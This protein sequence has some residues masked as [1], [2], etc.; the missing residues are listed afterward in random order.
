MDKYSSKERE[1]LKYVENNYGKRKNQLLCKKSK[2][3]AHFA[4]LLDIQQIYYIREKCCYDKNS[5]WCY[6]D[7]YFPK[8]RLAIEID[9][10]EHLTPKHKYRDEMKTKFL[11]EKRKIITIRF[12]NE[13]VI[14]MNDF[15]IYGAIISAFK[16]LSDKEQQIIKLKIKSRDISKKGI[17][18]L[19]KKISFDLEI[20]IY[21]YGKNTDVIYTFR[22]YQD[23][24]NSTDMKNKDL[25][26]ALNNIDNIY[27]NNTF[28]FSF[29]KKDLERKIDFYYEKLWNR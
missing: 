2:A 17:M 24:K 15:C 6:I 3:E 20:P 4:K 22:N 13:E 21:A 1:R 5:E 12:S 26:R 8:Y 19:K 10:K 9:G 14:N 29:S 18:E 25:C 7:F 27:A 16:S 11:L 28:I 23:L